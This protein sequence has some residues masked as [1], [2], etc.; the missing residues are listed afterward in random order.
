MIR[1]PPRSTLFPYTT[2]FRSEGDVQRVF[3]RQRLFPREADAQRLARDVRHDVI[4]EPV[5][6]VRHEQ[7]LVGRENRHDVWV[8]ELRGELH[9]ADEALAEGGVLSSGAITFTATARAGWR[10]WARYTR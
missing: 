5:R 6:S 1:R 8:A 3:Q 10:S 9:F 4:A 7:A 2:L